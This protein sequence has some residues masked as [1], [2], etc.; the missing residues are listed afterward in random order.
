MGDTARIRRRLQGPRRD[1][2]VSCEIVQWL[3]AADEDRDY[4]FAVAL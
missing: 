3:A 4:C 2:A 1:R